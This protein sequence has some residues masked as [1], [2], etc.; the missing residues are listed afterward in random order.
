MLSRLV[1]TTPALAIALG[2]G[3][4][5][6]LLDRWGRVPV[7]TLALIL[8]AFAGAH[9]LWAEDLHQLIAARFLF[10]LGVAG[11]MTAAATLLADLY[12]G[13]D[14]RRMVGLQ[15]A[16]LGCWG[17][18]SQL[19][20][21]WLAEYHWRGPFAL[22]LVAL[23][24][25]LTLPWAPRTEATP[26]HGVPQEAGPS[27]HFALIMQVLMLALLSSV[28]MSLFSLILVHGPL[29]FSQA[30]G[31][32]PRG[33]AFLISSMTAASS[34][35]S[36]SLALWKRRMR[37][38]SWVALGF[39][40]MAAGLA[41]IG[42]LPR[43]RGLLPGLVLVGLAIGTIVPCIHAWTAQLVQA[44]HRGR[45]LGVL[46]SINYIGQ[47]LTPF[48]VHAWLDRTGDRV[49]FIG[50]AGFSLLAA[51]GLVMVQ[52]IERMRQVEAE[53]SVQPMPVRESKTRPTDRLGS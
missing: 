36:L 42:L 1:L 9:G 31:I 46:T 26:A 4:M 20:A 7:L 45:T 25:G 23:L 2:A 19:L 52:W 3:A 37:G 16:L 24:L 6:I 32:G 11:V 30:A 43:M 40:A 49:L 12:R 48:W 15:A 33:T 5:G 8:F 53:P 47:F 13:E 21:G 39:L 41:L 50:S 44:R 27:M 28:G 35:A 18:V 38:V 10:G 51:G 29:Y 34:L 17:I 22:Y 14:L